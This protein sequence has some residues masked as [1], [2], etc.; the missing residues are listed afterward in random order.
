MATSV[1]FDSLSHFRIW[2]KSLRNVL[3]CFRI[4]CARRAH[5]RQDTH[6]HT[7]PYEHQCRSSGDSFFHPCRLS[8]ARRRTLKVKRVF[9]VGLPTLR[10]ERHSSVPKNA[11][12]TTFTN[13]L[14]CTRLDPAFFVSGLQ[15]YAHRACFHHLLWQPVGLPFASHK[16]S[17]FF[18]CLYI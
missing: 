8:A 1:T 6:F 14:N 3:N 4:G 2:I 7:C 10:Q 12:S 5:R 16:S 17:R 13:G 9:L 15:L 11:S 18:I